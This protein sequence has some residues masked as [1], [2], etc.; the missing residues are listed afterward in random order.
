LPTPQHR[1]NPTKNPQKTHKK[2]AKN[3]NTFLTMDLD[4][5]TLATIVLAAYKAAESP[6]SQLLLQRQRR[7]HRLATLLCGPT[8]VVKDYTPKRRLAYDPDQKFSIEE[9]D[10]R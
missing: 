8:A 3:H 10:V 7:M 6:L 9:R 2:S 5:E 1:P 4:A